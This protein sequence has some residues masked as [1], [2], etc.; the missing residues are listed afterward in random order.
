MRV[1]VTVLKLIDT[2]I[3]IGLF[4][5]A[6]HK[7]VKLTVSVSAPR[8]FN[9]FLCFFFGLVLLASPKRQWRWALWL[10]FCFFRLCVSRAFA[11]SCSSCSPKEL[12][13]AVCE[14]GP[15]V[16]GGG[17]GEKKVVRNT[18]DTLLDARPV[19]LPLLLFFFFAASR[20]N[21]YAC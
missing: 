4:V 20:E 16:K 6:P 17:G 11:K 14:G 10:K 1:Y 15:A 7:R 18:E 21:V 2:N 13:S 8:F 12:L 5:K 3:F 9:I 19:S